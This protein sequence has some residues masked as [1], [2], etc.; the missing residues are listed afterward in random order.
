MSRA[1]FLRRQL[2]I[3]ARQT[4]HLQDQLRDEENSPEVT[5]L[6]NG[7]RLSVNPFTG[8][9]SLL[10]LD[11]WAWEVVP[12][13]AKLI[14]EQDWETRAARQT[15][16]EMEQRLGDQGG[17][18]NPGGDGAA[19]GVAEVMMQWEYLIHNTVGPPGHLEMVLNGLGSDGWELVAIRNADIVMKRQRRVKFVWPTD[20]DKERQ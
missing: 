17:T 5:T 14:R 15:L 19:P 20:A 18:A 9:T 11:G 7:W 3:L 12:V 6:L 2:E 13:L 1:D 10:D 4:R 8:E 16:A